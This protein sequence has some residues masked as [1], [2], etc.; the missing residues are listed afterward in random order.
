MKKLLLAFAFIFLFVL[1][2]WALNAGHDETYILPAG[3]VLTVA[4]PPGTTGL[5]VRLSRTPGGG[6]A[7]SVTPIDGANLSF[8]A[9][10]QLVCNRNYRHLGKR[11]RGHYGFDS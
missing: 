10:K 8:G 3:E 11:L 7:Q 4:A 9:Y 2:V 6:D 1:S 5:A